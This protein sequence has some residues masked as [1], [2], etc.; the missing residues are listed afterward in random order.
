MYDYIIRNVNI[1]VYIQYMC[2]CANR[3]QFQVIYSH[4]I[5]TATK[6]KIP[7]PTGPAKV[8][9]GATISRGSFKS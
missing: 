2:L 4:P 5:K 8:L 9:W 3:V 7:N 1:C 6:N